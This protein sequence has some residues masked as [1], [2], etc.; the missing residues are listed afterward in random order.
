MRRLI[1]FLLI[2]ILFPS[3]SEAIGLQKTMRKIMSSWVGENY[4]TVVNHWGQPQRMKYAGENI[5]YYW[6]LKARTHVPA[7]ISGNTIYGGY[8][9]TLYCVRILSVNKSGE[10]TSWSWEGNYCPA[11]EINRMYKD[12]INPN[13]LNKETSKRTKWKSDSD[14]YDRTIEATKKFKESLGNQ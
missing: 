6:I 10:I 8:Y 4:N 12:W 3:Q 9:R 11:T 13:Y 14:E 5:D 2:F 1:I 7:N